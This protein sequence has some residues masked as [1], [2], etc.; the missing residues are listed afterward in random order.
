MI[1]TPSLRRRVVWLAIPAMVVVVL[2]TE[3]FLYISMRSRLLDNLDSLVD[4]RARL[5]LTE[6]STHGPESLADRLRQL[7]I[8]AVVTAPDGA[9]YRAD[10]PSPLLGTNLASP[11][12]GASVITREVALPGGGTAVVYA[13]RSGTD[14]ALRRLLV[15]EGIGLIIATAVASVVLWRTTGVALDPLRRIAEAARRTSS[16]QRGVRLDPDDPRTHLGRLA[17]AHDDMVAALERAINDANDAKE[18]SEQLRVKARKVIET[19]T[20]AYVSVDADGTV[21]D[22][23]AT[24]ERTFG[25]TAADIVGLHA[26]ETLFPRD[27]GP[28][29]LDQCRPGGG[30]AVEMPIESLARHRDGHD[31]AV[32]VTVWSMPDGDAPVFNAFLQD[33]TERRKGEEARARLAAVVDAAQEAIFSNSVDGTILTWNRG[34]ELLYGFRS[35]E[36]IGQSD[37][38]LVPA[39]RVEEARTF[40]ELVARGNPVPRQET[41]RRCK[42]GTEVDVALTISP[43]RSGEGMV[44]GASTIASDISEQRWMAQALNTMIDALQRALD[45]AK[46]SEELSRRFLADAAHQL[47]TPIAGIR[48]CAETLLR[49]TS[50]EQRDQLLADVVRETAR[51]SRLMHSLLRLAHLDRGEVL[52]ISPTDLVALCRCEA[53]RARRLAPDLDIAVHVVDLVPPVVPVDGK[54][55]QEILANLL[56]NARRHAVTCVDVMIRQGAGDVEVGVTDDGLG[57]PADTVDRIFERFVSLDAKGGSGLGLPIARELARAHGGDLIYKGK[58]F[59]ATFPLAGGDGTPQVARSA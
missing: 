28:S 25:W 37:T 21:T 46:A 10:P 6:A 56:D 49:G 32:E 53:D 3:V 57:V 40:S 19:A 17:A 29:P 1:H 36:A 48:A 5:V 11:P 50:P 2:L 55:V 41:V 8:R 33:I 23:N 31:I 30:W 18:R 16:G 39:D 13:R 9:V 7:G 12:Q 58:V 35:A 20:A 54:A 52:S 34:A 4:E 43:I 44:V 24:A 45:D 14:D 15:Y 27:L 22:W 42:N 38:I 59:V 47:C 26:A 51:A